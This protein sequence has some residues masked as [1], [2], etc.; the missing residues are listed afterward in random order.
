MVELCIYKDVWNTV[1]NNNVANDSGGAVYLEGCTMN[2]QNIVFDNNVANSDGGA[3]YLQ[4]CK[5]CHSFFDINGVTEFGAL[6]KTYLNGSLFRNNKAN[7]GGA[8]YAG[9]YHIKFNESFIMFSETCD[10]VNNHAECGGAVYV[11]GLPMFV[12]R[13]EVLMVNNSAT[14]KGGGIYL[15]KSRLFCLPVNHNTLKLIG[16]NASHDGGGIYATES[17][18]TVNFNYVIH[19]DSH[20]SINFIR[21]NAA[22]GGGLYLEMNSYVEYVSKCPVYNILNFTS[23]VAVL[24]GAI[25]VADKL[26][27]LESFKLPS[28]TYI[29]NCFFRINNEESQHCARDRHNQSFIKSALNYAKCIGSVLFKEKFDNCKSAEDIVD[30]FEYIETVSSIRSMDIGSLSIQVCFCKDGQPDCTYQLPLI[31]VKNGQAFTIEVATADRGNRAVR[32]SIQSR[33]QG[34]LVSIPE[35]QRLQSTSFGECTNLTF[36]MLSTTASQ[37]LIMSPLVDSPYITTVNSARNVEVQI[38]SC[39]ACPIGFEKDVDEVRGCICVCDSHL[40]PYITNCN[41]STDTV[42]KEGTTAWITY[43]NSSSNSSGYLIYPYCPLDYC[44]PS[45]SKV[46]INLNIPSGSDA[47]CA[48]NR[49][50]T[51]CGACKP[52]LS[53]SLGSSHCLQCSKHWPKQLVAII[54]G[55]FLAG[56]LLVTFILALNLTVAVGTLNGLIFYAN[57]VAANRSTFFPSTNFITVFI[58]WLN[59]ELGIDT[60]FFDGMDIY[61]KTWI[62]LA[63]PVYIIFLVVMIIIVSEHSVLFARLIGKKNPVATLGTLILL[64]YVKFIRTIITT[65]S[66]AVLDYPDDSHKIVW[67]PD[68]TVKYFSGKHIALLLTATLILVAGVAY[69]AILFSWQW[70]LYHQNGKIF[71]WIR[72]QRLFL[73]LEPYHAP[74]TFKHRYWTGLLLLVRI[75]LY[76]FSAVNVSGDPEINIFAT[77][78]VVSCLMILKGLLRSN[79]GVYKQWPLEVLEIICYV[80]IVWFCLSFISLKGERG[81]IASYISGTITFVLFFIVV[82]YHILTELC[83]KL[84]IWKRLKQQR[85]RRFKDTENEQINLNKNKGTPV[86]VSE[87]D[88]PTQSELPVSALIDQAEP[89]ENE[90]VETNSTIPYMLIKSE[91]L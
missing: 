37:Q 71:K 5:T 32:G 74:Y 80:N 30:E 70:L 2:V 28:D 13:G 43:I 34:G 15:E 58:A 77:G 42:T 61:W 40:K 31:K 24:G 11:S 82:V 12:Y 19:N 25:Y 90:Q 85:N 91:E 52:G 57:I 66:F 60:C 47:Q 1:F 75:I 55:G 50:G 48:H 76:I 81:H 62:E 64:S 68:A 39:I 18:V 59:L 35:E 51:L 29:P 46:E 33:M 41:T 14:D 78:I 8:I 3:I 63:F 44:F 36:N 86:T 65:F 49:H 22:R 20:S 89:I 10:L 88:P 83:F 23:N 26:R 84:R 67:L 79:N 4:G 69:T 16:N 45:N 7:R 53:L 27:W 38:L 56:I 73:F 54:A 87:V 21:N 6:E 72:Y 17:V 9:A